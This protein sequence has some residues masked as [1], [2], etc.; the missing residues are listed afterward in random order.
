MTVAR[1]MSHRGESGITRWFV[2]SATVLLGSALYFLPSGAMR[3]GDGGWWA[4]ALTALALVLGFTGLVRGWPLRRVA[5]RT[6]GSAFAA[7]VVVGRALFFPP[8]PADISVRL[9]GDDLP[10]AG[11]YGTLIPLAAVA[12]GA[13]VVTFARPAW[14]DGPG[15]D[16]YGVV[17]LLLSAALAITVPNTGQYLRSGAREFQLSALIDHAG[18][19]AGRPVETSA[20]DNTP[21]IAWSL[22][23]PRNADTVGAT[24]SGDLVVTLDK[25]S[26]T[27]TVSGVDRA[28]GAQR[29]RISINDAHRVG[30][31][32]M[33]A[34]TG[35]VVL[36]VGD[37]AVILNGATGARE[38]IVRMPPAP[39]AATWM[40]LAGDGSGPANATTLSG[41]MMPFVAMR[42]DQFGSNS[43]A[44]IRFDLQHDAI[45]DLDRPPDTGCGYRFA[46]TADH[47]WSY[48]VRSNCGQTTV[49]RFL[50][51]ETD[52]EM[53]MPDASC[54]LGCQVHSIVGNEN[55]FTISTDNDVTQLNVSAGRSR[56]DWRARYDQTS[57][58]VAMF[59]PVS[60]KDEIRTAVFRDG[61]IDLLDVNDGHLT[62]TITVPN[63]VVNVA[64]SHL[65]LQIDRA[66]RRVTVLDTGSLQPLGSAPL[67]CDP[68]HFESN[69]HDVIATC[70]D[71]SITDVVG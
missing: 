65:W 1:V 68:S 27:A 57:V 55:S 51:G 26:A 69:G 40:P 18:P 37:N 28:S 62:Q 70:T 56:I 39:D 19:A 10:P 67:P 41:A 42:S 6:G 24:I 61:A 64:M 46:D 53:T 59:L 3:L 22:S 7:F 48:L 35:Q 30:G 29:W 15:L 2:W 47:S 17:C 21:H 5:I 71:G 44:V 11:C 16:G 4:F 12:I 20:P 38:R 33:D 58:S 8:V 32:A 60:N 63:S 14:S 45:T 43:Y 54:E 52:A 50:R 31:I 9:L 49:R 34:D 36:P 13:I 25:S 23:R 66:A